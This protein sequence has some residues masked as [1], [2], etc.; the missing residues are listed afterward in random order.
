MR[1]KEQQQKQLQ[2][3]IS[4]S[5]AAVAMGDPQPEEEGSSSVADSTTAESDNIEQPVIN[6]T[7]AVHIMSN[8]EDTSVQKEGTVLES[9][10]ACLSPITDSG[11]QP[12]VVKEDKQFD[13]AE[14]L[15]EKMKSQV[16]GELMTTSIIEQPV[17][18]TPDS[19]S[20][21]TDSEGLGA[22]G[23]QPI[24]ESEENRPFPVADDAP[25]D[26]YEPVQS[27]RLEES[28][29]SD[30]IEQTNKTDERDTHDMEQVAIDNNNGCV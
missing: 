20:Q 4:S 18:L 2:Q 1:L 22:S 19:S 29:D 9:T 10:A 26:S 21:Q 15:K 30:T 28:N 6:S 12:S 16:D 5:V 7:T 11:E 8:A 17:D 27:S 14:Q 24:V 25:S 23:A 13:S 3:S